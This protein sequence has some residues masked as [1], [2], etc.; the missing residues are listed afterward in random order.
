MEL[1]RNEKLNARSESRTLDYRPQH[2]TDF[3]AGRACR[4]RPKVGLT[5]WNHAYLLLRHDF[6]GVLLHPESL[7]HVFGHLAASDLRE[8]PTLDP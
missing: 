4:D 1:P 3:R 8:I 5:S 2:A 6:D 7:D